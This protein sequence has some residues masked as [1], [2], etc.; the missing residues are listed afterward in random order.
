M[1]LHR[2]N[3]GFLRH[4]REKCEVGPHCLYI[5][6]QNSHR[7]FKGIH[8]I[9]SFV[10]KILKEKILYSIYT[11]EFLNFFSVPKDA[12]VWSG[13][14]NTAKMNYL[15]PCLLSH[16]APGRRTPKWDVRAGVAFM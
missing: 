4:K 11:P 14:R 8:N 12:M 15:N 16:I 6:L 2:K 5:F 3:I 9:Q 7:N 10:P 1:M 13:D